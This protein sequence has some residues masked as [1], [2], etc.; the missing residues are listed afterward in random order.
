VIS[1]IT[2]ATPAVIVVQNATSNSIFDARAVLYET[3]QNQELVDELHFCKSAYISNEQQIDPTKITIGFDT[4][5]HKIISL[6]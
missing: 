2:L 3:F 1:G 4:V 5:S 6:E